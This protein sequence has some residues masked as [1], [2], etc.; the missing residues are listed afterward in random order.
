MEKTFKDIDWELKK[1]KF[2]EKV[3]DGCNRAKKAYYDHES[4]I[5]AAAPLVVPILGVAVRQGI[6]GHREDKE[7]RARD[8]SHYDRRTDEYW[9]S[10]RPLTNSEKLKLETMYREGLSKGEALRR[11]RLLK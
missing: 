7:R 3:Q 6:K 10:R 11:M 2:W 1:R 8:C 9:E 4:D 5:R